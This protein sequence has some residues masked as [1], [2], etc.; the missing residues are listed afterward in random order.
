MQISKPNVSTFLL[1]E[2]SREVDYA[3]DQPQYQTLPSIQT[4][5]G[6]VASQWLPDA[7]ELEL[8]NRGVPVTLV[9]WTFGRPLQPV[10]LMVGGADLR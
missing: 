1:P 4:L 6:K 2:G 7:N 10:S 3:K 9:Y 5:D 8:L